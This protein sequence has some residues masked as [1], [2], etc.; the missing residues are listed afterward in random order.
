M[1]VNLIRIEE[2]SGEG[3][4]F[5]FFVYNTDFLVDVKYFGRQFKINCSEDINLHLSK[6]SGIPRPRAFEYDPET[7]MVQ[8]YTLT[9]DQYVKA[10]E[11]YKRSIEEVI[12][13][14]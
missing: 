14:K 2:K 13:G 10:K 3:L 8:L 4:E 7:R 6:V 1:S 9:D 5:K 11:V 12:F